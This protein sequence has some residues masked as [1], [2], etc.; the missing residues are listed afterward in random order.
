MQ[1]LDTPPENA[2]QK[3]INLWLIQRINTLQYMVSQMIEQNSKYHPKPK[4]WYQSPAVWLAVILAIIMLYAIYLFYMKE[5]GHTVTI[6]KWK[7]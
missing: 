1:Q 4:P 6:F 2:K 3:E 5:T 7:F